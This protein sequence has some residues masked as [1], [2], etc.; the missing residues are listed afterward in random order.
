LGN[1]IE[2]QIFSIPLDGPVVVGAHAVAGARPGVPSCQV[3]MIGG[4]GG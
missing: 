2:A 3:P 1:F 4:Q